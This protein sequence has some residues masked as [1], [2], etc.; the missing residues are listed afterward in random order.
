MHELALTTRART[1]VVLIAC[2]A[3]L[4][5]AGCS[6]EPTT[7]EARRQRGDEIVRRMSDRL[8]G[9]RTF[10]VETTDTRTRA[11]GGK[12]IT[13]RT[14]RRLTVRRPDRLALR[15]TG[16]VDLRGWYDGSKLTFVS[17]PH[18]V[19]ARVNGAPTIDDTLDRLADHL[20]MPMPMAD[21]LYS[22]P[23][24]ALIGTKSTGGYVGRETIES[25][26][27]LHVAYKHPAVDWDLWVSEEG[28]PLP[29]KFRVTS[30]TSTRPRTTEVVFDKWTL[31]GEAPDATFAPEVPAGYE[32]VQ[33]VV[34]K[35]ATTG[36]APSPP[37]PAASSSKQ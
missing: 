13:M 33:I 12:E 35:A 34:G 17:D 15:V 25:V 22:S 30:K 3:A 32:R 36:S 28:D 21:F 19:W 4:A 7:P 23:Y 31:G 29:K 14:T 18:K 6:R 20:A 37:A 24:D 1:S 27:C 26:P 11:R 2:V 8:A 10:A 5:G 9:A 16:D